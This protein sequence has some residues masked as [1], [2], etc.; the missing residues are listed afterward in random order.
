MDHERTKILVLQ[1]SL[2]PWL[3][4]GWAA[5][6]FLVVVIFTFFHTGTKPNWLFTLPALVLLVRIGY[7]LCILHQNVRQI[8]VEPPLLPVVFTKDVKNGENGDEFNSSVTD[9]SDCFDKEL[10]PAGTVRPG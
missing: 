9:L 1:D 7:C 4:R 6:F 8:L 10:P 3:K 5:E 2:V